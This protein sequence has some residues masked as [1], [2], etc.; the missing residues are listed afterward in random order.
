MTTTSVGALQ[1]RVPFHS[2]LFFPLIP[3]PNQDYVAQMELIPPPK[4]EALEHLDGGGPAPRRYARVTVIRGSRADCMDF[5]V[6]P[7]SR[8]FSIENASCTMA[9]RCAH[10][11]AIRGSRADC[12][13][14]RVLLGSRSLSIVNACCT[15]AQ[16]CARIIVFRGSKADCLDYKV[17]SHV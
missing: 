16:R 14:H 3:Q 6:R 9:Q 10:V 4:A 15:M 2:S 12:M 1:A 17:P 13:D 8:T 7:K 11:T 5:K